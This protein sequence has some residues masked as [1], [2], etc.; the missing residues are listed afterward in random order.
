MD[1]EYPEVVHTVENVVSDLVVCLDHVQAISAVEDREVNPIALGRES[2]AQVV[3]VLPER[4][5]E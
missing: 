2:F 1:E 3:V 4:L 5:A